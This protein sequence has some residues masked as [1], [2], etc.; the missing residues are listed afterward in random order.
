MSNYGFIKLP[1]SLLDDPIWKS[2]SLEYRAIFLAIIFNAAFCEMELD[3]FG[4]KTLIRPGQLLMTE[5]QLIEEA[6]PPTN[7]SKK[8]SK[9]KSACHRALKKFASVGFSNHKTNHKKT[10]HTILRE[11]IL[12]LI[13]PN[14]EPNS[15]QTR[16]KLEPQKKK[17]KKE[18]K[19][20]NIN[21]N[22]P[23]ISLIEKA[24]QVFVSEDD[25]QKLLLAH[26]EEFTQAC[27][28]RLSEWKVE[29][30]E[31]KQNKFSD[32]GKIKRW[33]IKAEREHRVKIAELEQRENRVKKIDNLTPQKGNIDE[34]IKF[35]ER[36]EKEYISK[37]CRI[38]I[39]NDRVEFT[40]LGSMQLPVFF[41]FG[42]PT[43]KNDVEHVLRKY[44]FNKISQNPQ[45]QIE[46]HLESK[47][48]HI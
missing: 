25:H 40:P 18:K 45:I 47:I 14:F 30:P 10:I 31:S 11:D 8:I 22:S 24:K 41:K 32:V 23:E 42:I 34:D 39:F 19:E 5:R 27:Y 7:D 15:N 6:F 17:E 3:D 38:D 20:K 13:E 37:M 44:G 33:V 26:G 35:I 12:E 46:T 28:I 1:R 48:I 36:I 16:T 2:F 43:F 29:Q 21:S 4:T 9:Y